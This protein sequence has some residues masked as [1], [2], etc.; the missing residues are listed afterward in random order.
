[1]EAI[2][3]NRSFERKQLANEL[4]NELESAMGQNHGDVIDVG[5]T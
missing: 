3:G 1:M 5:W 4:E 2:S